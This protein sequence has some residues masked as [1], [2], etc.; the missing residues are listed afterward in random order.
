[1]LRKRVLKVIMNQKLKGLMMNVA[2]Q[3]KKARRTLNATTHQL[4]LLINVMK[5]L[6]QVLCEE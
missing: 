1:M 6:Y 4:R 3:R 5:L 2:Y